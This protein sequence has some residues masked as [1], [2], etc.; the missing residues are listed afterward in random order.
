MRIIVIGQAAFG[1]GVLKGL[2]AKGE[3]IVAAYTPPDFP[4]AAKDIST[5]CA[6]A[7]VLSLRSNG[8]AGCGSAP[9]KPGL[10]KH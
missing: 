8:R 1:A 2:L 3:E 4:A 10:A 9:G 6:V 7:L 5:A